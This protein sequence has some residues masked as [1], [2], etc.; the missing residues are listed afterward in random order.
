M[1]TQTPRVTNLHQLLDFD[2]SKFASAEIQLQNVLTEWIDLAGD[3]KLKGILQRYLDYVRQHVQH[4]ESFFKS[5]E[6]NAV[7]IN[8][9]VMQAFIEEAREKIATCSEPEVRDACLL[10]N[11]QAIN[12]FKKSMYGTAAA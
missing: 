11:V 5:E 3:F 6:M 9:R 1:Q 4:L 2:A 7:A 12:N 10:A 8:N